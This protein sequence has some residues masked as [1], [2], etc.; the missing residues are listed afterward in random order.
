MASEPGSHL[1]TAFCSLLWQT[2]VGETPQKTLEAAATQHWWHGFSA[3]NYPR[4]S[5]GQYATQGSKYEPRAASSTDSTTAPLRPGSL[6]RAAHNP[7]GQRRR[8]ADETGSPG[9]KTRRGDDGQMRKQAATGASQGPPRLQGGLFGVFVYAARQQGQGA[10]CLCHG[11]FLPLDLLAER[12][13]WLPSV[14]WLAVGCAA[15]AGG[16]GMGSASWRA[17]KPSRTQM[18]DLQAE[19]GNQ[20]GGGLETAE[21]DIQ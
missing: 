21:Q 9:G 20:K 5:L 1:S 13:P 15:S 6:C 2:A 19:W 7:S 10:D 11:L 16:D 12:A 14:R 8:E 17:T 4:A 3:S 18:I